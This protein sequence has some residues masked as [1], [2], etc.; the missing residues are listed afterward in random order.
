M[1]DEAE[2]L[3]TANH[4]LVRENILDAYGHISVR[5]P[6]DEQHFLLA[7]YLPPSLVTPQDIRAFDLTG[8]LVEPEDCALYSERFIHAGVYR[9]R[10]DVRAVCHT[11]AADL[12][13]FGIAG[14]E[15]SPVFH[16]AATFGPRIP[17]FDDYDPDC[18]LLINTLDQAHRL[19]AVLGERKG[20][21]MRG[22]GAIVTGSTLED[23]VMSSIYLAQNARIRLA[24][25]TLGDN[26]IT[27]SE[28]ECRSGRALIGRPAS[29]QRAW[30][31]FA[32]LIEQPPG[33]RGS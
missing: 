12:V 33:H 22:H 25:A 24:A 17:I 31:H 19:A 6:A 20:A 7:R 29:Q 3:S 14:I 21:L 1:S 13:A 15:P 5:D 23:V 10:P 11:H 8:S 2:R 32:G 16:M 26:V 27:L 4:I 9:A 30:S 18:G 28:R